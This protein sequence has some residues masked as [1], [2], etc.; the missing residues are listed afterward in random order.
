ME[1]F[2]DLAS[3]VNFRCGPLGILSL[4]SEISIIITGNYY[5]R[6][7]GIGNPGDDFRIHLRSHPRHQDTRQLSEQEKRETEAC[8]SLG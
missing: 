2:R 6:L 4:A 3:S 1:A 5:L 8:V 7:L